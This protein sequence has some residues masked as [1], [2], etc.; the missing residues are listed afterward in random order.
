MLWFFRILQRISLQHA[1]QDFVRTCIQGGVSESTGKIWTEASFR[2]VHKLVFRSLP[3]RADPDVALSKLSCPWKP[4]KLPNLC[5]CTVE[6]NIV[7]MLVLSCGM[8]AHFFM[9]ASYSF[10][11]VAALFLLLLLVILQTVAD[12]VGEWFFDRGEFKKIDCPYPCDTSCQTMKYPNPRSRDPDHPQEHAGHAKDHLEQPED[13]HTPDLPQEPTGAPEENPGQPLHHK[14]VLRR[15][16]AP[17]AA[18]EEDPAGRSPQAPA[19]A[20]DEE[21]PGR[22]PQTPAGAPEEDPGRSQEHRLDR[23]QPPAG[24]P[25]ENPGQSQDHEVLDRPDQAPAGA[26]EEEYADPPEEDPDHPR[27]RNLVQP[28]EKSD[29]SDENPAKSSQDW[30]FMLKRHLF[31]LPASLLLCG[32]PT[33]LDSKHQANPLVFA[34]CLDGSPPAY[35]F[36]PGFGSGVNNWLVHFELRKQVTRTYRYQDVVMFS[37]QASCSPG[38][39]WCHN[40]SNCLYRSRRGRLGSSK[41]MGSISFTGILNDHRQLNPDFFNWNKVKVGYCDGS[42]FTGDVERVDPTTNLYYRGARIFV[43][44]MEDLLAKGMKN[45]EN[46]LLSGCSAGGLASILHCDSFRAFL[47]ATARVK[48]LSDSGF[49]IN[50]MDITGAEHIKTYFNQIVT[51][52]G[53]AKNL[54]SSCTSNLSPDMCFF[55]Q[56]VVEQIQTPLFILNPA[57]DSWQIRNVLVPPDSDPPGV[58]KD[59]RTDISLCNVEQIEA[60]QVFRMEFLNALGR[61]GNSSSTGM[62]INS[63]FAH[64]QSELTEMWQ[65]ANSPVLDNMVSFRSPSMQQLPALLEDGFMIG[66]TS[67]GSTVLT[68][69]TLH[70]TTSSLVPNLKETQLITHKTVQNQVHSRKGDY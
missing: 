12:A 40:V 42:S 58:W 27:Y 14:V 64:C 56:Y 63:C 65:F 48:C 66:V 43:A 11:K 51:T 55:P 39:G 29:V 33:F 31:L 15:P 13:N 70:A 45:A 10:S 41:A 38:G 47:P 30:Q 20:P 59:C 8:G 28:P 61:F 7:V 60:M 49:F 35:H 24:A 67:R 52:H 1:L 3:D 26:P 21:N 68:P 54:P 23:P 25:E 6:T 37:T 46:A 34:V 22:S 57:Y 44:V 18:P 32:I 4:G 53:S 17:A 16:Q 36:A 50:I 19:G 62:F 5:Q 69:V 2:H 9:K